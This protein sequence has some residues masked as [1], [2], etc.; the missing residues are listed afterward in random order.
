MEKL[1]GG[2]HDYKGGVGA[3]ARLVHSAAWEN[4]R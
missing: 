1:L 2:R 4:E 3:A